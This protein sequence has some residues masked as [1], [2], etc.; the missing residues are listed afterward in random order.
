MLASILSLRPDVV[1]TVLEDGAVLLDLQTK[2]F[3]SV[4][5]TGW[6]IVQWLENGASKNQIIDRCSAWGAPGHEI[7]KIESFLQV[8]LTD[9][10]VTVAEGN[11]ADANVQLRGS[12]ASPMVEKHKEPLQRIMVSAFD[13]S[14]PLAE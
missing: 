8:F 6:V 1:V 10:L 11:P 13:P 14:L 3:Y 2:F 12:W 7:D 5:S 4:N 9:N